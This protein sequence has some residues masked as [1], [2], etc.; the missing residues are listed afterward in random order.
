MKTIVIVAHPN[1]AASTV[2]KRWAA[3]AETLGKD[4]A[5]HEIYSLYPNWQI[6]VEK[7]QKLLEQYDN[8]VFQF[9]LYWYNC[10]PLLKKYMDDVLAYGWAYGSTGGKLKGKNFA[11]AV[12][13]G[14]PAEVYAG[15]ASKQGSL[16]SILTPFKCSA[17]FCGMTY[18]GFFSVSGAL[19]IAP[20]ALETSAEGYKDFLKSL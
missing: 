10:P 4:V 8:V 6:D 11:V 15:D 5:V 13:T 12:S 18:K 16:A 20:E 1:I 7:E 19:N 14:A 17:E 3:E 9:P 2:N